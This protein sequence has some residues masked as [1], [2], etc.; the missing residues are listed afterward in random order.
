MSD[1]TT[2]REFLKRAAVSSAAI[3]GIPAVLGAKESACA[4]ASGKTRIV[5]ARDAAMFVDDSAVQSAIE[6]NLARAMTTLMGKQSAEE[7]WRSLFRPEDVVGIK[8]NCL[9]G[10]TVST[11]PEI[12]NAVTAGL[13]LAG[14]KPENIIV[15]DRSTGDLAKCGFTINKTG[16]GIIYWADDRE[17]GGE[18]KNGSFA[19]KISKIFDRLT[20]IVN[21]P[22]VK[23]HGTSGISCALKN[24]YGSINNPG[25][26]HK[27]NCDPGLAE[28]NALPQIKDKT[29]LVVADAL[30]PQCDGGPRA[31]PGRQW[32]YNS[33][34][35]GTDPVAIDVEAREII[36]A[37]RKKVG[38]AELEKETRWIAS[39]AERG[40]GTDDPA[41][42]DVVRI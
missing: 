14:I 21:V 19:G 8:I 24:H 30:K 34:I 31:N 36:N 2:R 35:V 6:R 42:I 13:T 1:R 33:I 40:V 22:V 39:A 20:A 23:H 27:N 9:F 11:R 26:Y 12:V 10:K 16:P 7:A 18:V 41:K 15:W 29:R 17:W 37:Q 4:V 32:V 3:A 28:V 25:E 5:T 38:L